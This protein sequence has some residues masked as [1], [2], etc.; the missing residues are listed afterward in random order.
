MRWRHERFV[1]TWPQSCYIC[2]AY[3]CSGSTVIRLQAALLLWGDVMKDSSIYLTSKLLH[4]YC[5]FLFWVYL[6]SYSKRLLWGDVM[7]DSSIPD[8]KA[9]TFVLHIL[10][11]G[12]SVIRLQAARCC[13]VTSWK[14]RLYLT[15]KLLHLYYTILQNKRRRRLGAAPPPIIFEP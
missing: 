2:I 12:I 9:A 15:S 11:L 14:I 13:E 1:H 3:F 7:K 6:S 5:I 10:V 8:L 4:L